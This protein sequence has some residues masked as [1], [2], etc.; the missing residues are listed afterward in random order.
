MLV[1]STFIIMLIVCYVYFQEGLFLAFCNLVN[2]F[3]AFV[4]V[5]GFYEPSAKF[6]AIHLK[7][8]F[9]DG[10]E[11]A[12]SMLGLFILAFGVLKFLVMTL[13]P[14]VIK[15]NPLI[16][17][18]GGAFFGLVAGY[19]ISGFLW[20]VLQTLPWKENFL[21]FETRSGKKNTSSILFRPDRVWL[22]TMHKMSNGAFRDVG[23]FDPSASFEIRYQRYR[24][25]PEGRQGALTHM[26]GD[27]D[28]NN[29]E[30]SE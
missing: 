11:D 10:F 3:F 19:V 9:A 16:N 7:D 13:S 25:V 4:I 18:L 2:I 6:I 8:T 14:S 5:A 26:P 28:F 29:F 24:R 1:F 12:I 22:A 30:E 27:F 17:N 23:V 20:C 21:G 15:Y